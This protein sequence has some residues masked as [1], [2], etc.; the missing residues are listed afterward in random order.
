V[1]RIRQLSRKVVELIVTK[2]QMRIVLCIISN[3]IDIVDGSRK[4]LYHHPTRLESVRL[5]E[6]SYFCGSG[7][8]GT[9]MGVGRV[10]IM[11]MAIK[12]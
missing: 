6:F 1:D 12:T 11:V 10:V 5:A 8:A 2:G 4:C 3:T 7:L 9:D